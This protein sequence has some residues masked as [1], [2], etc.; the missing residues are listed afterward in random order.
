MFRKFFEG[1]MHPFAVALLTA[2][3]LTATLPAAAAPAAAG[4][5][6]FA[7]IWEALVAVF[8]EAGPD[9]DPNGVEGDAGGSMDRNG[10]T[11]VPAGEAGSGMDP[12][13]LTTPPDD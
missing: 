6:L 10:Y 4:D 8:A 13:G 9:M 5:G 12:D 7:S 1:R 11:L 2:L 3:L